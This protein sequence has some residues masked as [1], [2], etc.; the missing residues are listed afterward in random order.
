MS[1][2]RYLNFKFNNRRD[3]DKIIRDLDTES[4]QITLLVKNSQRI[5]DEIYGY[6]AGGMV[7]NPERSGCA[8]RIKILIS[9]TERIKYK[10][11]K[12][13]INH[14]LL[15]LNPKT[16]FGLPDSNDNVLEERIEWNSISNRERKRLAMWPF[17]PIKINPNIRFAPHS[18]T[19][20]RLPFVY[21]TG[22]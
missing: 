1:L 19:P 12:R 17:R 14:T 6:P 16:Q 22:I 7:E 9:N 20:C 5:C 4:K 13:L 21:W 11:I 18:T 8:E 2:P 15:A 10:H 3:L